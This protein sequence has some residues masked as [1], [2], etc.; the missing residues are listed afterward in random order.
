[1]DGIFKRSEVYHDYT[2]EDLERDRETPQAG[3]L[4]RLHAVGFQTPA[5]IDNNAK[6]KFSPR[7]DQPS[8][9]R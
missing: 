9:A 5:R 3:D 1:M 8:P 7:I 4:T 6:T 2:L